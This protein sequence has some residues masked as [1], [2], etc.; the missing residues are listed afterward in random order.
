MDYL[1]PHPKSQPRKTGSC[2][3]NAILWARAEWVSRKK[4]LRARNPIPITT[5]SFRFAAT[6]AAVLSSPRTQ[7]GGRGAT[8][9]PDVCLPSRRGRPPPVRTMVVMPNGRLPGLVEI[10]LWEVE[11]CSVVYRG[12]PE[13]FG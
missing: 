3:A 4:A 6:A 7:I 2:I 10:E 1:D 13:V 9:S 5:Y 8:G 12:E 11:D